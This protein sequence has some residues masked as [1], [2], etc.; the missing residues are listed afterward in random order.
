MNSEISTIEAL[1]L[2]AKKQNKIHKIVLMIELGDLREGILPKDI[3]NYVDQII[4]FENIKL[5]GIGVNLTCYGGVIPTPTNLGILEEIANLIESKYSIVLNIISGGNSSSVDLLLKDRLPKKINNL[6]I[7]EALIFGRETA[8]GNDLEGF[9]SDAVS[10]EVEI[11][12]LKEKDSIPTGEIG[13]NAFG[14]KPVFKD[15]GKM[16]R[17]IVAIGRQD[18]DQGNIIPCDRNISIIGASSDHLILDVTDTVS[19]YQVGDIISFSL[20]YGGLL[21]VSTSKYVNK[22][23]CRK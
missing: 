10:L 22:C 17:A 12:E 15:L 19:N 8:Y 6:R 2:E 1:N 4:T 3:E 14:E 5:E 11:V 18:V 13:M 16:K 7:G 21:Q 20:N 9:F 23:F